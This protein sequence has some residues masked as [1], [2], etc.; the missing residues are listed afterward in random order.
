[1]TRNKMIQ[2][3]VEQVRTE[4]KSRIV[5]YGREHAKDKMDIE[6]LKVI[7]ERLLVII[8]MYESTLKDAWKRVR[9][10]IKQRRPP[11]GYEP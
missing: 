6:F 11:K 1:M 7:V 2:R 5:E 8:D 4:F 3:A 10:L 9:A